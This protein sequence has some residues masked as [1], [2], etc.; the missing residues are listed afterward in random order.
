MSGAFES[1]DVNVTVLWD[2]R[3]CFFRRQFSLI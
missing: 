3:P 2:H 1:R